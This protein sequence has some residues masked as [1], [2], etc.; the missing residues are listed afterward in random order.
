M[1]S[2]ARYRDITANPDHTPRK[3]KKHDGKKEH[4]L[5]SKS[6]VII[7]YFGCTLIVHPKSIDI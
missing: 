3:K 2:G 7:L 4:F 5:F 6:S 1:A